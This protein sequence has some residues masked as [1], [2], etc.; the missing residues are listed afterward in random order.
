MGKCACGWSSAGL[1][2]CV[3]DGDHDEC[4]C[5]KRSKQKTLVHHALVAA[6]VRFVKEVLWR[7]GWFIKMHVQ[8][9]ACLR[10]AGPVS[11]TYAYTENY[12]VNCTVYKAGLTLSSRRRVP[13]DYRT[14]LECRRADDSNEVR[15]SSLGAHAASERV[16]KY[17]NTRR[18]YSRARAHAPARLC[19]CSK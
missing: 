17:N 7:V 4:D 1:G 5:P 11:S 10:Q 19:I 6:L 3:F 16:E 14:P 13:Y 9:E 8:L 18:M 2:K 15:D 12:Y